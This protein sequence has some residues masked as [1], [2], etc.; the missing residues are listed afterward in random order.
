LADEYLVGLRLDAMQSSHPI[1]VTVNN[2]KDIGQIFDAISYSKGASVIRMLNAYLGQDVFAAGVSE[3]LKKHAYSNAQDSDLWDSLKRA[4]GKDV[5]S[6]MTNWTK[7]DGFPL[8]SVESESYDAASKTMTLTLS[9]E[10]CISSGS[11][12]AG[13]PDH[14]TIWIVPIEVS[15]HSSSPSICHLNSESGTIS[16]PYEV[17][18][19]AFYKLNCGTTG[20][21]RVRYTSSNLDRLRESIKTNSIS[22]PEDRIGILDDA[23]AL[24]SAGFGS[25]ADALNLVK[26]FV[27]EEDVMVLEEVVH[28]LSQISNVWF[29]NSSVQE[30]PKR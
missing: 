12:I 2:P 10:R 17:S 26:A 27:A 21:Y 8:I 25:T 7:K 3:Y 19:P 15:T 13:E 9:Q 28:C 23:F 20:F 14:S 30:V 11:S 4:S 1:D 18:A 24:A 16:F 22:S 5:G 29:M 6:L